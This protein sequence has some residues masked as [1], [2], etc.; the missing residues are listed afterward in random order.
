MSGLLFV[1]DEVDNVSLAAEILAE[2]LDMRVEV[3]DS[4]EAAV[5]ALHATRWRAVK[6]GRP[7]RISKKRHPSE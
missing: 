2:A 6:G 4:V 1:D 5:L 7:V 3:V